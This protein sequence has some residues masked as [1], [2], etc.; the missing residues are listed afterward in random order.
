MIVLR[1]MGLN[2][3]RSQID[4]RYPVDLLVK[5]NVV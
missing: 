1:E 3:E 2:I 5:Q 4:M